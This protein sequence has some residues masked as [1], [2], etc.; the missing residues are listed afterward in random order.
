SIE[1][2]SS[3][4]NF[5][6]IGIMGTSNSNISKNLIRDNS[7]G[8]AALGI[9]NSK[10]YN[11]TIE[12]N[13]MGIDISSWSH[14]LSEFNVIEHNVIKNGGYGLFLWG[15]YNSQIK[16]NEISINSDYGAYLNIN[17]EDNEIYHN[18]FTNNSYKREEES[19]QACDK[20]ERNFWYN[21]EIKEGNYWD[22]L[23]ELVY[24]IDGSANSIDL[25]P[26]N[27][28]LRRIT[29]E[30]FLLTISCLVS[31]SILITRKKRK[32]AELRKKT[33]RFI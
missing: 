6:G 8:I 29:T 5:K 15:C 31:I 1:E 18:Y 21:K 25:Y 3:Y 17:N 11:N 20:G 28:P 14:K 22:D 4:S 12:N 23:E 13:V 24:R 16:S 26:L 10:I 33:E 7:D 2:N 19:K 9:A 32:K 30:P 27:S